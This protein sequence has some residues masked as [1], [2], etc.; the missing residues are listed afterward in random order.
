MSE[1]FS[2][3]KFA[4]L[5][6]AALGHSFLWPSAP[7][8]QSIETP[9]KYNKLV[10]RPS[11]INGQYDSV[12]VDC[13][14]VFHHQGLWY[15]TF[16]AFDGIG[17][18]TGLA[19]SRNLVGWE[20]IGC[21]LRRDPTSPIRKYNVAMNWILRENEM[22]SPGELAKVNGRFIGAYHAYPSAG[23]ENGAAVIGIAQS[24]DL[25]HWEVGDPIL[26]PKDGEEWERGGL[27]K[28]CLV[29]HEGKYHLFYNA[30]NNTTAPWN[31]QTGVVESVDLKTWTRY[32]GNPII[33]NGGKGSLDE[34]F[35]SDPCVLKN[36]AE[37]V[38]FYFG[39]DMQGTARELAATGPD[40][41]HPTKYH[42]PLIDIGPSGSIDSRY[43]HK[44]S[45]V[46]SRG[47]LYHFYCAVG[48]NPEIRGISVARSRPW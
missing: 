21:I 30:K 4:A 44:P 12:S 9:F 1:Q 43:A 33:Q 14:F 39:L 19:R 16:V 41:A 37:W 22:N 17:Y 8:Q 3:R 34:H 27:Y 5:S 46:S 36:G 2:R 40:L 26:L 18:Q 29:K 35:A 31:E 45:V 32:A 11:G 6:G 48:G 23:Y 15:M 13:P 20:K 25:L 42:K 28:P 24:T 38:F 10:L 47:N 7:Q